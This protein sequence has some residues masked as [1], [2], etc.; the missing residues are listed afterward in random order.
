MKT[1]IEYIKA[2]T[3]TLDSREQAIRHIASRFKCKPDQVY[4]QPESDDDDDYGY[5]MGHTAFVPG[6]PN[7]VAWLK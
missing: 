3:V 7:A 4:L 5:D 6:N 1:N 2:E